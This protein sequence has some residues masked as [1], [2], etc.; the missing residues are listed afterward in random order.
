M[1]NLTRRSALL[2]LAAATA[3]PAPAFAMRLPRVLFVCQ[4][5]TVKSAVARELM[6]KRARERGIGVMVW[7]RGIAPEDHMTAPIRQRLIAEFGID[8]ANERATA[9]RQSDLDRADTVVLFDQLPPSLHRSKV[10]NWTDQPSLLG[11][12]DASMAWLE[13]HI[14]GLLDNLAKPPA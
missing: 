7:S 6:R 12:F 10:L 13:A 8:P 14:A 3:F 9:L 1:T 4:A 5:G 11:Q 2:A